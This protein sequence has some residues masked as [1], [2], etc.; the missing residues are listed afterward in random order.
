MRSRPEGRR[1]PHLLRQHLGAAG[2]QELVNYSFVEAQWEQDFNGVDDPIRVLNPIASQFSVMRT[3]LIGGLVAA[4]KYNLNR[5][6]GRVRVYELGRV[7]LR[8]AA[9]AEAPL[10]VRGIR[11]PV[12]LAALAYGPVD[13]EQW[14]LPTRDVDFFDVKGDLEGML[15]FAALRFEPAAHPALHPGRSARVMLAGEPVGWIGELHP[16][17]QQKYELP[18]APVLFELDVASLLPVALP[19]ASAVPKFPEALRDVALWFDESVTLQGIYD[20]VGE[21]AQADPRLR[22]LR[23]FRLFDLY[24][25]SVRA[26]SKVEEVGANA[27]LIK[28]KSLAF[29][30]VLQDTERTLAEAQAEAAVAAIVEGLSTRLNA[31]LRQ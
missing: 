11:Q 24:R 26:S 19:V 13:D 18:R 4:L 9:A 14:G 23:Q 12:R 8:D 10:A 7:F 29:R 21:L 16:R 31:R 1:T 15:A 27:L 17:W 30:L 22:C 5:K 25:P 3:G 2:Y 28:E 20:V 6:A